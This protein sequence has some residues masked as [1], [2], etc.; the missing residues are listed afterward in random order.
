MRKR[1]RRRSSTP[2][3]NT[4]HKAINTVCTQSQRASARAVHNKNA[5]A[6]VMKEMKSFMLAAPRTNG[7]GWRYACMKSFNFIQL[8]PAKIPPAQ[9]AGRGRSTRCRKVG[10]GAKTEPKIKNQPPRV[11]RESATS[12]NAQCVH[13]SGGCS[14]V[15]S[16][17]R[18]VI[19]VFF[20]YMTTPCCWQ[21]F[22]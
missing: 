14:R 15:D 21:P 1:R 4:I 9:Q 17:Q 7:T 12:R 3:R 5:R 16:L 22:Y 13:S 2:Y 10:R 8:L 11:P 6:R 19:I 18:S 20:L